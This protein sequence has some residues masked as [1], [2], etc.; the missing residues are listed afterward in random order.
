M[1]YKWYVLQV[2]SGAEKSVKKQILDRS[3]KNNLTES[4]DDILIPLKQI[5]EVKKG[6]KK[7]VE[8][9][10]YP[11]YIFANL[12]LSDDLWHV[13]LNIPKVS[14]FVSVNGVPKQ[15]ETNEVTNIKEQMTSESF[16]LGTQVQL[17]VGEKIR[18]N[19]GGPFDNFT[20]VIDQVDDVKSTLV[21]S[22]AIFGR[23]TPVKLKFDQIE[24][25]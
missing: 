4:I 22:V 11:G 24:K 15:V 23:S 3:D 1:E 5:Q 12:N 16:T 6:K 17:E 7:M 9:N 21:V 18:I 2:Y 14:G 19:D 10:F 25:L 8:K 20:G 13:I